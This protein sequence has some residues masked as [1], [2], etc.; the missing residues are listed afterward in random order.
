MLARICKNGIVA[1]PGIPFASTYEILPTE[2]EA[3]DREIEMITSLK[4]RVE[5]R[6][7]DDRVC[8]INQV[9]GGNG[10]HKTCVGATGIAVLAVLPRQFGFNGD[11]SNKEHSK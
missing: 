11:K 8:V 3:F 10:N 5:K 2:K 7:P 4:K 6:G 9:G 1:S